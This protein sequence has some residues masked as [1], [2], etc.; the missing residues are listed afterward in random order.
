MKIKSLVASGLFLLTSTTVF[1]AQPDPDKMLLPDQFKV[2]VSGQVVINHPQ[3]GFVEK[4]LPTNNDYKEF[5]GCYIACYSHQ[6]TNSIYPVG[7]DIYVIGQIRVPGKY[8]DRI[9][10]PEN[11]EGQDISTADY[12]K[13]LCAEKV[14]VCKE[15]QCWGGGDTGGWFGIQASN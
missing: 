14:S 6:E 11:F 13:N 4:A 8:N 7:N 5:P 15:S 3:Q 1:A 2:Y 12:F 10:V 9:C